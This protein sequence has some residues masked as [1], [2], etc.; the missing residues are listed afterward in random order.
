MKTL[1]KLSLGALL[2]G[3]YL[4]LIA[5]DTEIYINQNSAVGKRPKV[6]II[7]DNSGSMSTEVT[8]TESRIQIARRVVKSVIDANPGV[9]YGLAIFN[10]ND[11]SGSDPRN[12]GRIVRRITEN[13]T[14]TVHTEIKTTVEGLKA[15]TWTP[16]CETLSE[17]YRYYAG[18]NV[19]YGD[20][21]PSATPGQDASA[22]SGGKYLSPLTDCEQA[23]I[24]LM[25]D[26][27]PTRDTNAD[28]FIDKLPGIGETSGNRL[29]ELAGWLYTHDIDNNDKN[30]TQRVVTYT[31]GFQTDHALLKATAENGG[32]EYFTANDADQLTDAFQSAI[33]QILQTTAS[34]TSPSLAVNSFNRTRS[35]NDVYMA[36]FQ[37]DT[38]PRWFGNIK[39][40][41][42]DKTGTIVDANGKSA[43][44]P[45]TQDISSSA[46]TIWNSVKDGNVVKSGGVGSLLVSRNPATR[47]IKTDTGVNGALENFSTTN[48]N[49]SS[50]LLGVASDA[51]REA[52][53]SW[54]RGVD[55]DDEDDDKSITDTRWI[56]GDPLHSQPLVINY[57]ARGSYT[58]SKPD[59]RIVVGTNAGFL[60]MFSGDDGGE[61]WAFTPKMFASLH[62]ILRANKSSSKHPYA[63][64][65][66][67]VAYIH[68]D[69]N[70]GTISG[71]DDKVYLFFGL[72]R[73]GQ[74][75]F[76]LDI[77][78]PDNPKTIW[79]ID[80]TT[81]GFTE[82]GQSWSTPTI[83]EIAGFS[84]PVLIFGAGFDPNKDATTVGTKDTKG[85]G[86]FI[87][88]A[89]TGALIW[90]ATP[91]PNSSKNLQVAT[92]ED[93]SPGKVATVDSNGD[94]L[95]D[96]LYVTDTG[97][98]IWRVDLPGQTLP[99]SA[100]DKWSMFKFATVGGETAAT[101]RRFYHGVDI[102]QTRDAGKNFDAVL[103][104]TG[105]RSHPNQTATTD[106]FYMFKDFDVNSSFHG[107]TGTKVP[108]PL[109]ESDLY[110][111]TAD[112]V[113]VGST[114]EQATATASLASSRGW[115]ITLE[116]TGEKSLSNSVT[117]GGIVFFTTFT[118]SA[119]V[120]LCEPA[121]GTAYL[122]ALRLHSASSVF[123]FDTALTANLTKD[124]RKLFLGSRLPSS[125]TPHFGDDGI[126]ILGV[127]AGK[128]GSGSIQ[129]GVI[130]KTTG[131]Y[132]YRE[133]N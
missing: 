130:P 56:M 22:S 99:S 115:F 63:I 28:N 95:V 129:T 100:Q 30:G 73:G 13:Q 60:H 105:N 78:D 61:D 113:Q 85:R 72:Q 74:A 20:D 79:T 53:I 59:T 90:S 43:I 54:T 123:H 117:L 29:D 127:G 24:I 50:A 65:G 84:G 45:V 9:D 126:R 103:I 119:Q 2:A 7:F 101:D 128:D 52:L 102:I 11:S 62:K 16:L 48:T 55:L 81:S 42:I 6:L 75:Y 51:E 44:D 36:M 121:G 21:D 58:E 23:Y 4:P 25:T 80:N 64:D 118:P 39:K 86:V 10:D 17:A 116:Q 93:S 57:G 96:R 41:T 3:A 132:W 19:N 110:D 1:L 107:S 46:V 87:V 91:D 32:G 33:S 76:A 47:V 88:D 108:D 18:L 69:K 31:I 26:G 82:L 49:L 92:M 120:T 14:T 133:A 131:T 68:D 106:K 111:A 15:L 89:K 71:V 97:G 67:P 37:P 27:E 112:L 114:E 5:D 66:S 40:L 34:F 104:G 109:K 35:L 8:K 38:G 83:G 94:K 70:D 125:V 124:D 122:Y 98:N 77:S 12:G